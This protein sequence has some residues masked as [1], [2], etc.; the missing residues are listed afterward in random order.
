MA[1]ICRGLIQ[2]RREPP[3]ATSR[4]LVMLPLWSRNFCRMAWGQCW[5]QWGLGFLASGSAGAP[6]SQPHHLPAPSPSMLRPP[7]GDGPHPPKHG[8]PTGQ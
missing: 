5:G 7:R 1:W 2:Q 6:Y 8:P 3:M 4:A